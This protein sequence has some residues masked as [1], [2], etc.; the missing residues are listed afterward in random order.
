[1]GNSPRKE[2]DMKKFVVLL[3]IALFVF[4]AQSSLHAL[5]SALAQMQL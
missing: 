1:M 3:M 4:S 2:Y 5:L